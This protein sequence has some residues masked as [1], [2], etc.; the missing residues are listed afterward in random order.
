M[1][2]LSP[3]FSLS[4]L[5]CSHCGLLAW[6]EQELAWIEELR[7]VWG[8][9]MVPNSAYRCPEHPIEAAKEAPGAHTRFAL[10]Q[11]CYGTEALELLAC[12]MDLGFSGYGLKQHGPILG[13]YLH[14]DREP[15]RLE[16]PRPWIWSY[17]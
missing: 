4:E 7:D 1:G 3:H 5:C 16:A 11:P 12:A 10:D 14:L 17:D 15:S 2:D 6:G 9:P 8:K 13:R